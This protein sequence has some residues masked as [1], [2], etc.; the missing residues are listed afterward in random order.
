MQRSLSSVRETIRKVGDWLST[1]YKIHDA[2]PIETQTQ[3]PNTIAKSTLIEL[4]HT[5]RIDCAEAP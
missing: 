2:S 4:V 3:N 5:D 1:I